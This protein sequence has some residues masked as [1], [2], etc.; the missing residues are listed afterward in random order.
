MAGIIGPQAFLARVGGDEFVAVFDG[1]S[2][3]SEAVL[4]AERLIA[5]LKPPFDLDGR[6]SVI[7]ASIGVA[8]APA[9]NLPGPELLRRADVAMYEAKAGGKSRC[10]L[11]SPNIDEQRH[12][13]LCIAA[14]LRSAILDRTVDVAYQPIVRASDLEIVAVEALARWPKNSYARH[15][16]DK[17]IAIAEDNGLIDDLGALVLAKACAAMSRLG[18]LRIAINISPVQMR[19][20]QFVKRSL[21]VIRESGIDPARVEFEMTEGV[22]LD[23]LERTRVQFEEL[24]EAGITIALDDFGAGYSSVGYLKSIQFDRIK[25]DRSIVSNLLHDRRQQSI[26]QGTVMMAHGMSARVLAEGVESSEEVL[27]LRLAGCE[28]LQ[29]YLF[30]RPMPLEELKDLLKPAAAYSAAS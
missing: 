29:G 14:E 15:A 11:Y 30:H 16:P 27:L 6:R 3:E 5:H 24:R 17:F 2:A 7:G 21:D 28:E 20:P 19:S 8:A 1:L 25:I 13:D 4:F 23:N 10:S 9:G 12:A 22:L 18:D 26:I